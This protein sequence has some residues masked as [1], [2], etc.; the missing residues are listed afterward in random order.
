M[1]IFKTPKKII[2]PVKKSL[3][4]NYLLIVLSV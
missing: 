2:T 1:I 4:V 3:Y